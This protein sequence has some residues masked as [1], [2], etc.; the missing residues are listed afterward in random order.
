VCSVCVTCVCSLSDLQCHGETRFD[1]LLSALQNQTRCGLALSA[2][3]SKGGPNCTEDN[4]HNRKHQLI[5]PYENRF[6]TVEQ[7][8]CRTKFS[9]R[10]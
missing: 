9:L 10:H 4:V 1:A 6:G 5:S 3:C 2:Q 8:I 7:L